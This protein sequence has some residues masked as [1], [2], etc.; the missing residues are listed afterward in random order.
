MA[1]TIYYVAY[2]FF[3]EGLGGEN[4]VW[5]VAEG[6]R[7]LGHHVV[8]FLP[9]NPGYHRESSVEVR[10]FPAPGRGGLRAILSNLLSLL[11]LLGVCARRRPDLFYLRESLVFPAPV[12]VARLFRVPMV[13]E[14]N[15]DD[16]YERSDRGSVTA[17]LRWHQRSLAGWASAWIFVTER[18]KDSFA[19]RYPSAA[20]RMHVVSN[21][22]DPEVMFSEDQKRCLEGLGLDPTA[23]YICFVGTFLAHQG[24]SVLIESATVLLR[25]LQSLHFLLVGDGPFGEAVRNEVRTRGLAAHFHFSG[26]VS[27]AELRRYINAADL[28][29]APFPEMRN[30]RIGVSPLKLYDYLACGKPVVVTDIPGAGDIVREHR[31][32]LVVGP[33][34]PV[35]LAKAIQALYSDDDLRHECARQ[36]RQVVL[37]RFDWRILVRRI[38]AIC[39]EATSAGSETMAR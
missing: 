1:M 15:N 30:A 36:A 20:G 9:R 37:D 24:L 21:G 13:V 5:H 34:D 23:F 39:E 16:L 32:G 14:V 8:L 27:Y 7:T 6:L 33:D 19:R 25:E 4:H 38:A 31:L 17:P 12:L 29:V 28:C 2:E 3:Q 10:W 18:L 26:R 11:F 35:A 22:T